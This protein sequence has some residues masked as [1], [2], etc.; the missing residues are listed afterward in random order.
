MSNQQIFAGTSVF[1]KNRPGN[2]NWLENNNRPMVNEV[3]TLPTGQRAYKD[4]FWN[5]NAGELKV[6]KTHV[7]IKIPI[8]V[9]V[10]LFRVLDAKIGRTEA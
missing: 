4:L 2:H 6:T 8:D 7:I 3:T 5:K 1:F 9:S 10:P